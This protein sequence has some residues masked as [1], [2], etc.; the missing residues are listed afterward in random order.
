MEG[1]RKRRGLLAALLLV[2]ASFL[3]LGPYSIS[4]W[5]GLF[6]SGPDDD[7]KGSLAKNDCETPV[8]PTNLT[9]VLQVLASEIF[10]T[11][12]ERC[13]QGYMHVKEA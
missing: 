3:I 2:A 5:H 10:F 1:G 4:V 13:M 11:G 8:S 6:V 9:E 12:M 7:G